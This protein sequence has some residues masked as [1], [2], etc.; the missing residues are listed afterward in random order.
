MIE[1]PPETQEME[2]KIHN[3]N[4]G[5]PPASPERTNKEENSPVK[6]LT[7]KKLKKIKKKN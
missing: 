1:S 2:V 6:E 5:T 4:P 3:K 7:T